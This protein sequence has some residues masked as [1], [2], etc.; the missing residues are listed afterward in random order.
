MLI[1]QKT[2]LVVKGKTGPE[3]KKMEQEYPWLNVAPLG[4]CKEILGEGLSCTLQEP[5]LVSDYKVHEGD[6]KE[7]EKHFLSAQFF[8]LL[9]KLG[10]R[11]EKGCLGW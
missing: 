8:H 6:M 3:Q 7:R 5:K 2:P 11:T 10:V 1:A 9:L 4:I